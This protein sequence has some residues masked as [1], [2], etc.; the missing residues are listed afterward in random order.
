MKK[1]T[2][3]VDHCYEAGHED[4]ADCLSGRYRFDL[5]LSDDEYEELYNV[6]WEHDGELNGWCTDWMGHDD[7][8]DLIDGAAAYALLKIMKE[9]E[10]HLYPPVDALWELSPETAK[11]F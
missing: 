7:L 2:F 6:W 11:E 1:A 5:S 8:F 4:E 3:Y 10:P 9:Q